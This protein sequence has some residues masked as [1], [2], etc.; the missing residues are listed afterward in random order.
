M[1]TRKVIKELTEYYSKCEKCGKEIK[2]STET[3]VAF[4]MGVHQVSKE[5]KQ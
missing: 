5:C 1:K 3:M 2:G 4:N